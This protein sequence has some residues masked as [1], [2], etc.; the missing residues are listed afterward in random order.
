MSVTMDAI[1]RAIHQRKKADREKQ[2]VLQEVQQSKES[3]LNFMQFLERFIKRRR[4]VQ[5]PDACIFEIV[6]LIYCA[7]VIIYT[8]IYLKNET[9]LYIYIL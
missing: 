8:F 2:K 6:L 1:K 5:V 7:S 3:P 9:N 4:Y